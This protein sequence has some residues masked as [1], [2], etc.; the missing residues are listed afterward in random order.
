MKQEIDGLAYN[1][2]TI[3]DTRVTEYSASELSL[4]S[5]DAFISLRVFMVVMT[6]NFNSALAICS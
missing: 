4:L 5:F 2:I 6:L 1:L 3:L